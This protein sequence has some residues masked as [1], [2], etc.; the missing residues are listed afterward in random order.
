MSTLTRAYNARQHV[1]EVITLARRRP[2]PWSVE[3]YAAVHSALTTAE[4][5]GLHDY[6]MELR[7]IMGVDKPRDVGV[8]VTNEARRRA[9]R[10]TLAAMFGGQP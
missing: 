5:Y 2:M 10:T 9:A 7:R 3:D 4:A 8:I 1:Y 6:V